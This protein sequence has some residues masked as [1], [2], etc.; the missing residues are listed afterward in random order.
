MA[1]KVPHQNI[2][3]LG[4]TGSIGTQTLNVVDQ[5]PELFTVKLL[6]A[7]GSIDLLEKQIHHYHPEAV[8]LVDENKADELRKKMKGKIHVLSGYNGLDEAARWESVETLV[9]AVVGNVGLKP[10]IEAIVGGARTGQVGDGKI[11]VIELK[12][13]LRIRT[14]ETGAVAVG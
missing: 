13:V 5:H 4:S 7:N 6:T 8:C 1:S 2:G 12:D 10:T 14:G 11:F 9:T 3:I